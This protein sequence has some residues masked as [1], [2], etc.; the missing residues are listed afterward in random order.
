MSTGRRA[1][2]Y[3]G[4][5]MDELE[6]TLDHITV[7]MQDLPRAVAFYRDALAPLGLELVGQ[8]TAEASGSVAFAGFGRGRKGSFWLAERG[9]QTPPAHVCFRAGSRDAVRAFR[10]AA[11]AA[12]GRDNGGP[13]TRPEYH[14]AYY[15]AFVL[16]PEGHNIEA[17]TFEP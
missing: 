3:A 2:G 1:I 16:D 8:V 11:L 9:A 5:D 4:V 17:V 7:S 12:G 13:G 15:A 10:Q 6:L 14:D